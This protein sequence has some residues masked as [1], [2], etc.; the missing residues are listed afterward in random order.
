M[1]KD[2]FDFG[3]LYY[4]GQEKECVCNFGSEI[5]FYV[6]INYSPTQCVYIHSQCITHTV[7]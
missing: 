7:Q 6:S 4:I 2:A 5:E 1:L 3:T